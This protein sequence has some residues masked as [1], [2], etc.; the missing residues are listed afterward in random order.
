MEG[1]TPDR[2]I[3]R[4]IEAELLAHEGVSLWFNPLG[5]KI[6]NLSIGNRKILTEV[7]RGDGMTACTHPCSPNFGKEAPAEFGLPRHGPVR[8]I[9]WDSDP[10]IRK[11]EIHRLSCQVS[12]GNYPSGLELSQVFLLENGALE[13]STMHRNTGNEPVPVNFAEH[14]YFKTPHNSWKGLRIN[15]RRVANRIK[16]GGIIKLR[17]ENIISFPEEKEIVLKQKGLPYAVLWVGKNE[18]GKLDQHYVCIEP[19]EGP[20]AGIKGYKNWFGS[21]ESMIAPG[22]S[23]TTELSLRLKE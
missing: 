21:A 13:I 2:I 1:R 16:R 14:C 8:N 3:K 23:R 11:A 10:K 5:A 12:G 20:P 22:E 4:P 15:G 7:G 18:Q 9:E 6:V 17:K 19:A